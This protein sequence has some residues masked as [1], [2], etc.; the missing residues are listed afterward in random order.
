MTLVIVESPA[1]AKKIA[2]YLGPGY[3]VQASLGHV[4]DLP[5]SRAEIPEQY[6]GERWASLGVHP[7]TFR[8]I[9]VVPQ[10]KRRTVEELR[11][12]ARKADRVLFAAD[13][14]REGEAIA[15]HLSVLLG[16]KDPVRLVY[17][18]ITREALQAALTQTRP[19]NLPLV[20]AQE[21]RRVIDRL[22][23][24][25]VSPLLW[26]SVGGKLSAGRVQS[27]ALMLLAQREM[28]R[29]KFTPATFWTLRAD[30][31]TRPKFVATVT[32]VRTED[33]PEGHAIARASDFTEGGVLKGGADVLLMT[34]E[35]AKALCERLDGQSAIVAAVEQSET[36]SR[37]APPFTTSTLQQA[38]ARLKLG[39]KEVMDLAQQL[40]ER[41]FITYMRTDSPVL[42]EEA[43]TESRRVATGLFGEDAVPREPRQYATRNKNAQEAHEAI[44]PTGVNWKA[45]AQTGLSGNLLALYTLVYQRTV[46]SQMHDAVYDK[47]VVT[48]NCGDAILRAQG[49]VLRGAGYTALLSSDEEDAESQRLPKVMVGQVVP[50]KV[51]PPEG[52][53]TAAPP[54]YTEAALVQ[55]MERAGIGRPSTYAQTLATLAARDYTRPLGRALAVTATG[56]LVATYLARQVPEVAQAEFTA[57][58]EAGLDDVAAGHT[59]RVAYLRQFWTQGLA[60]RI[61]GA[62][63]DPPTLPLP[64]LPGARLRATASGVK[65]FRDG[66]S[67]LLPLEALPA[68]LDEAAAGA[69]MAGTWKPKKVRAAK[70]TR[71]NALP[72]NTR[73]RAGQEWKDRT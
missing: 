28:A 17:S 53:R 54:R 29:M 26:S 31:L 18:E 39:A 60:P 48:L 25:G 41:G 5:G 8:P 32:H 34:D 58:M 7:E 1:K 15:W 11:A 3:I 19:L 33:H 73:V 72:G 9:Y 50:L 69:V 4:R 57:L 12:L 59:T 40:Y 49:R 43:L 21:S 42:S 36:R 16:V 38:G 24:Y 68:E 62:G 6:A 56:L 14:D 66:H 23:G 44:R 67:A 51:R 27:A 47:T 46:A 70:G 55:A 52:K 20:A 35:Q 13:P 22:V 71:G 65:L 10:S 45:P 30:V 63:D 64:H 2:G 61:R 37:P